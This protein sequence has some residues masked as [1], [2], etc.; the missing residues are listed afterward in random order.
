MWTVPS[1]Y[2]LKGPIRTSRTTDGQHTD[3]LTHRGG[4][5]IFGSHSARG[6]VEWKDDGVVVGVGQKN[7]DILRCVLVLDK[8]FRDRNVPFVRSIS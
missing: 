2:V 6:G 3:E 1:K 8:E 4:L 7:E 5:T